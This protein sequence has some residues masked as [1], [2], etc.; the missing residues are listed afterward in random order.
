MRAVR[1][2]AMVSGSALPF[3]EGRFVAAEEVV[4]AFRDGG[5]GFVPL[6]ECSS[7]RLTAPP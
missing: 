1:G 4:R 2:E 3:G 6:L 7:L 5:P